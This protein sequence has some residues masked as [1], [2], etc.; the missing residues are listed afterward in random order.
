MITKEQ[1]LFAKNEANIPPIEKQ[2]VF[3]KL[4]SFNL[5]NAAVKKPE[6]VSLIKYGEF[7]PL[8]PQFLEYVI[9]NQEL[10][11]CIEYFSINTSEGCIYIKCNNLQ[12]SFHGITGTPFLLKLSFSSDNKIVEW[13]GVRLQKIAS[14]IFLIACLKKNIAVR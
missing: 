3:L 6:F 5:L 13:E 14:Q 4:A 8:V 11:N 1:V 9:S 2:D 10:R 7:K 12:F